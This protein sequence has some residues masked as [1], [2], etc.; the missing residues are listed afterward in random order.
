MHGHASNQGFFNMHC[1]DCGSLCC[2]ADDSTF[3]YS[4]SNLDSLS[5]TLKEK[6]DKIADFMNSNKLKL[7]GEKTH[8]MLLSTDRGWRTRLTEDSLSLVT[9][10]QE[11]L[12]KTMKS[13]KLLGCVISQNLKWTEYILLDKSS[14]IKQLGKR[15]NALKFRKYRVFFNDGEKVNAS[16]A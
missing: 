9:S 12:V 14:L 15:I 13:E 11:P 8:L 5:S 6:Y 10:E 2:Y 3:S 1:A 4:S 7:N 16:Y